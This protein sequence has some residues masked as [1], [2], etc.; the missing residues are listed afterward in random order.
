[1]STEIY[2][3]SGTGNSLHVAKKLQNKIPD[4]RLIPIV[5][6]LDNEVIKTR[7]KN[8]GFVFPVHA[9]TIPTAVKRF[10]KKIDPESAEYIFAIATRGGTVF[11]GFDKINK[12]L[13]KKNKQLNS[14]FIL[15]MCHNEAPRSEKNYIVPSKSD[16]LQIEST[17]FQKIDQISNVIKTQSSFLEND[18]DII[19]KSSS[20]PIIGFLIEKLVVFAM[21]ISE[22]IGGVNYFCHDDKCKG[23]GTCEKVCL[24]RK[25]KMEDKRPVWQRNVLCYMCFAC[26][27]LCPTQ[28]IQIN[29]IP[30][31]KSYTRGNGRYNH[32]YATANDIAVQKEGGK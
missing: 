14:Q 7:G 31:I 4:T 20:N 22:Y 8:V 18:A 13:G 27:N 5:S 21:N 30:F 26:V 24:S 6:L 10:L 17:V 25:I 3:F 1:M 9:L 2:Y 15:N 19:I 11:R 23:C 28:A 32:P 29:D 12:L 16:I